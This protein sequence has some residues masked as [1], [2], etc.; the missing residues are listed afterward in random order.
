MCYS[1]HWLR[2]APLAEGKGIAL[3]P[4]DETC[5]KD[6]RGSEKALQLGNTG[7]GVWKQGWCAQRWEGPGTMGGAPIVTLF[8]SLIGL[9]DLE[10]DEAGPAGVGG[11]S[12]SIWRLAS[13]PSWVLLW[14]SVC[15]LLIWTCLGF[16]LRWLQP[17][18]SYLDVQKFKGKC[19]KRTR[20]QLYC[21][22]V[23]ITRLLKSLSPA[24]SRFKGRG[25]R[26]HFSMAGGSKS[27]ATKDVR[28]GRDYC[29][30]L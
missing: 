15:G 25:H 18:D 17:S 22:L 12:W 27:H 3:W 5:G 4:P 26:P 10:G 30:Y 1:P 28:E 7:T 20:R 13:L 19:P 16:L 2:A 8:I 14:V 24:V 11:R 29:G 23:M 9:L 21:L 6:F